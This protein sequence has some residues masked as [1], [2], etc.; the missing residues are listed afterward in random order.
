MKTA[1]SKRSWTPEQDE[2]LLENYGARP[3]IHLEKR[4]GRTRES[5]HCRY[6]EL[7]GTKDAAM[8]GGFLT[9]GEVADAIH[10]S[11]RTVL[12]WIQ[13]HELKA[14][15]L[16]KTV[17]Q[18][19]EERKRRFIKPEDFWRWAKKNKEKIPF[20]LLERN[21][22][23]PEPSW[24]ED[25]IKKAGFSKN[26]QNWSEEEENTAWFWYEGGISPAEIAERLHRT[27]SGVQKK[28]TEIRKRKEK[29]T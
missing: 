3:L 24:L 6:R 26:R 8:A 5:I 11:R 23:L 20:G 10:K 25:E 22:I 17:K 12:T 13:K 15:Q 29:V 9:V 18:G 7:E 28:L 14:Y 2:F 21:I 16:H 19:D 4:L 27:K 1:N